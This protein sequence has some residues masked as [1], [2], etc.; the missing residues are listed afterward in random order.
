MNYHVGD[1]RPL[2]AD[3]L[4]DLARARVRLV[5]TAPPVEPEREER[6][7]AAVGSQEAKLGAARRP[8][9]PRTM[10]RMPL[11]HRGAPR[12]Q[13]CSPSAARGA[14]ARRRS[15]ARRRGSRSRAALRSRAPP[16]ATGR[17]AASR[18]ARA[19]SGRRRR[20]ARGCGPPGRSGPR[21][22]PRGHARARSHPRS[23][24]RGRPRRRSGAHARRRPRPRRP[25]RGPGR[26]R[27]SARPRSRR[28]RTDGLPP[29][30][31][32]G[33]AAR[34]PAPSPDRSA[35]GRLGVGR[36]AIHEHVDVAP[37]EPAP[38]R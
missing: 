22:P 17:P 19:R 26:R 32:A 35:S 5:E 29:G 20:R 3:P 12:A 13:R 31:C 25:Q 1:I 8:S 23:A 10:R 2:A 30:A 24:R 6:D 4:L 16:R 34:P 37:H 14:S 9:P 18:A 15:P 36:N 7:Q 27:R 11:R 21:S 33:A 38:R 28:P